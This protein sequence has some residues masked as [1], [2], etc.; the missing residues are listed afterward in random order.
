VLGLLFLPVLLLEGNIDFVLLLDFGKTGPKMRSD[1]TELLFQFRLR[2]RLGRRKIKFDEAIYSMPLIGAR[3]S[4]TIQS[5]EV[6]FEKLLPCVR[7][8]ELNA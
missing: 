4:L 7:K 6:I 3:R 5:I 1:L 2:A 8:V